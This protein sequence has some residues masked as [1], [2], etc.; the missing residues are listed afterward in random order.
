MING[1]SLAPG[2]GCIGYW[3]FEP[4]INIL[5]SKTPQENRIDL[6]NVP[7][8]KNWVDLHVVKNKL[9]EKYCFTIILGATTKFSFLFIHIQLKLSNINLK[10]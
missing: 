6:T 9:G 4:F 10:I 3:K 2:C 5:I 1:A 7:C 8:R